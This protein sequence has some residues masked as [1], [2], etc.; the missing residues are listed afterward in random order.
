MFLCVFFDQYCK[1]SAAD[2][3]FTSS[4]SAAKPP[5]LEF[6]KLAISLSASRR[7]LSSATCAHRPN[8]SVSSSATAAPIPGSISSAS[9]SSD[10]SASEDP[11]RNPRKQTQKI[12]NCRKPKNSNYSG[13]KKKKK[14]GNEKLKALKEKEQRGSK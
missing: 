1:M 6:T 10:P 8:A 11:P 14:G 3:E 5:L 12:K 13:M 9:A 4:W 2:A 7:W